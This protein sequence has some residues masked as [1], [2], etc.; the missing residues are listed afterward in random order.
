MNTPLA[1]WSIVMRALPMARAQN[2]DLISKETAF[3]QWLDK[4]LLW[5]VEK[6][7]QAMLNPNT[8]PRVICALVDSRNP[9]HHGNWRKWASDNIGCRPEGWQP[10]VKK[11]PCNYCKLPV[12]GIF[13]KYHDIFELLSF[14]GNSARIAGL[15]CL[16][17]KL[18]LACQYERD[19]Y[20]PSKRRLMKAWLYDEDDGWNTAD[21]PKALSDFHTRHIIGKADD[22][23]NKR[24]HAMNRT[25]P[26][27]NY[28]AEY[29]CRQEPIPW[30]AYGR[31]GFQKRSPTANTP[32]DKEPTQWSR[33]NMDNR[34]AHFRC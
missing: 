3:R 11:Y 6:T 33:H 21:L 5:N 29:D 34:N 18:K 26:T 20:K 4:G 31:H 9:D 10:Y 8:D 12:L 1:V 16:G 2:I 23:D 25:D 7:L 28:D 27:K 32:E 17:C 15:T 19:H 30:E 22:L 13:Y 14:H 24:M